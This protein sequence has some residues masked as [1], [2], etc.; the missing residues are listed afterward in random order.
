MFLLLDLQ[1]HSPTSFTFIFYTH[2]NSRRGFTLPQLQILPLTC[3]SLSDRQHESRVV[4]GDQN[5]KTLPLA[6]SGDQSAAFA[7]KTVSTVVPTA[8]SDKRTL[9]IVWNAR[10]TQWSAQ[11][12]LLIQAPLDW[13]LWC[14]KV[15]PPASICR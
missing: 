4:R 10:L 14:R 6:N 8:S 7:S 3:L 12:R 2:S 15:L 5:T 13:R 9:S 1:V 11:I